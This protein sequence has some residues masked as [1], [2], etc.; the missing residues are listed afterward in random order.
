MKTMFLVAVCCVLSI[1]RSH[2]AEIRITEITKTASK[3]EIKWTAEIGNNYQVES[4]DSVKGPW[5][6]RASLKANATVLSWTDESVAAPQRFY[7]ISSIP[8]A[9]L[10]DFFLAGDAVSHDLGTLGLQSGDIGA[11]A[12][13]LASQL[14][15]GTQLITRGTLQQQGQNWTYAL[16]PDDRL[17]VRFQSGTN[18]DFHITRMEGNFTG[19]ATSFLQQPH[20]FDYRVTAPGVGDLTF[21]SEIPAGTCNFKAAA[22]GSLV[23]RGVT[24]TIDLTLA[25]QYCVENGFGYFSLLNDYTTAG[26]VVAPGFDLRVDQ[27]RRFELITTSKD[28]AISEEDWNNNTLI[29]GSDTYQ[30]SHTKKQKSF[31]DGKP[32]SVDTYWQASGDVLRNGAPYGVYQRTADALLGIVKFVLVLPGET[33]DLE[34]WN[35]SL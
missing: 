2:A 31:K 11:Q 32:S 7:R 20:L 26:T 9:T 25:G 1:V 5:Q 29:I 16:A 15:G 12:V 23:W 33:I 30:W 35:V 28:S 4:S 10:Q 13:F 24:Y 27:R 22:Q 18:L 3:S 8:V 19:D 34:V 6:N 17:V 14:Q 21:A